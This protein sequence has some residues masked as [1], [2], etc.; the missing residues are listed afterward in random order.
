MADIIT[1]AIVAGANVGSPNDELTI[2]LIFRP[3]ELDLPAMQP[4][5]D[6][7]VISQLVEGEKEVTG[8]I[9]QENRTSRTP[10]TKGGLR[11]T[12]LHV[13]ELA[14]GGGAVGGCLGNGS[15]R[16]LMVASHDDQF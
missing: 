6:R 16:C 5:D 9:L 3:V 15:G 7:Y 4:E 1:G 8:R 12:Q 11:I 14:E 13:D 2:A 10:G